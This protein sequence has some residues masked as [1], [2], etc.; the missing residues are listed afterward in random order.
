MMIGYARWRGKV[1]GYRGRDPHVGSVEEVEFYTVS[2]LQLS[3]KV[4][5]YR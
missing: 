2:L 5:G 3:I 1:R 4:R